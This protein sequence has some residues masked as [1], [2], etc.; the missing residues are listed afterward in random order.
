ML[1]TWRELQVITARRATVELVTTH[2]RYLILKAYFPL[3]DLVCLREG[4]K[5]CRCAGFHEEGYGI[6]G[7]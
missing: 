6:E 1:Y 5:A 2:V 4:V 7:A 3:R